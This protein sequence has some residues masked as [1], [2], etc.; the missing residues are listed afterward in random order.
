MARYVK[1]EAGIGNR[2]RCF[3]GFLL[4]W[5]QSQHLHGIRQDNN[6]NTNKQESDN[7]SD[8]DNDD[9][10]INN[11][12]R[13]VVLDAMSQGSTAGSSRVAGRAHHSHRLRLRYRYR[14]HYCR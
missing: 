14:A 9:E 4:D 11:E 1:L 8:N 12:G 10:R 2:N 13:D 6:N 7:K 5:R 3:R